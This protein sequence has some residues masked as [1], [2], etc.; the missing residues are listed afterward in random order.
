MNSFR[1]T[2]FSVFL[3]LLRLE[4]SGSFTAV[5]RSFRIP[6]AT[7]TAINVLN[8]PSIGDVED[9]HQTDKD[10]RPF[11]QRVARARPARRLNHAFRYLHRHDQNRAKDQPE[12]AANV[13]SASD[14]LTQVIGYSEDTVG[15]PL[16]PEALLCGSPGSR[17]LASPRSQ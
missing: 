15:R 13:T 5:G 10:N 14:F 11:A 12:S 1:V 3:Y 8:V 2:L 17:A 4:Y 16:T 7:S 9:D 6:A